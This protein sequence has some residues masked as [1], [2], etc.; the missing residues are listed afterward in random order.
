MSGSYDFGIVGAGFFGARIA[1]LL[2]MQGAHV[3]LIDRAP[4]ICSRASWNNQ[5]RIH[6]GYHYPRSFSTADASHRNYQR[7]IDELPG[8]TDETFEHLYAIARDGSM[9]SAAQFER[10]CRELGLPLTRLKTGDENP[11]DP[12]RIEAAFVVREGAFDARAIQLN[13]ERSLAAAPSIDVHLG[14]PVTGIALDGPDA[15]IE[16]PV[17]KIRAKAVIVVAYAGINRLL[18]QSGLAP[19]DLKGEI[20]ELCLVDV[21]PILRGRAVTVMDGPFFSLMPMPAEAAH[22]F[23]HV[24]YT[25]HASWSLTDSGRDP[26]AVLD[27]YAKPDRFLYMQRDAQRFLPALADLRWRRSLFEVK[28]IPNRHEID[29]GRPIMVRR[30]HADPLCVSVLGAKIDSIF[31]LERQ[32]L[33]LLQGSDAPADRDDREPE[34]QRH[35]LR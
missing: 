15:D 12:S 4:R 35:D 16:G 33:D 27:G 20:A 6:N 17:G 28:A 11:F 3:A 13:L 8:C 29:D 7:F 25:P 22:S 14:F 31:E 24:R 1:L 9:T 5:A 32:I 2:A 21:P 18:R 10:F 19:L 34:G 26:Y 23:T 30:H